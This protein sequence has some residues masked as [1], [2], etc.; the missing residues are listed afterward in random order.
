MSDYYLFI[1]FYKMVE[2]NSKDITHGNYEIPRVGLATFFTKNKSKLEF[3]I[4][5]GIKTGI[6]HID[7]ASSYGNEETIGNIL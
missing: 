1:Y 4:R 2:E 6:Y 5:E 3:M 7:T